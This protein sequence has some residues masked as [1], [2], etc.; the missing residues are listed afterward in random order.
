MS[1]P[2]H[3]LKVPD[4]L[5]KLKGGD[6]VSPAEVTVPPL[7]EYYWEGEHPTIRI[8]WLVSDFFPMRSVNLIV[9][10]SQAG[11]TFVALDLAVAVASG[12]PFFGKRVTKGGVLYIASEGAMTVPGRL[13]A[14]R[15]GL[16]NDEKLI[17]VIHEPPPDLMNEKDVDRIIATAQRINE[18]ML[19]ATGCPLSLII[20][21]TMVSSFAINNWNE[22]GETS[23]AMKM[24]NRIKA[25]VVG[26]AV[27]GVH[28]HGK[29]T[30][31]GAAGS[32]ALTASADAIL[33]VYKKGEDGLVN[34]R[35]ISL[36]KSR[37]GETGRKYEFELQTLPPDQREAAG[38]DQAFVNPL[39]NDL[40]GSNPK[41][42]KSSVL[43]RDEVL[44][45][46]FE[47]ALKGSGMDTNHDGHGKIRQ[48]K[49]STV[50]DRFAQSYQ[51]KGATDPVGAKQKAWSRAILAL[52][53]GPIRYGQWDGQEWLYTK[54][55]VE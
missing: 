44:K 27:I 38:D 17:A 3:E 10:E 40:S 12:R 26:A 31:R 13:K 36:T 6:T 53:E 4:F 25:G 43:Q 37:F 22:V 16:P 18:Q 34:R 20:I 23:K 51:T 35:Y 14:A 5:A 2:S 1:D 45:S 46:A 32:Y 47:A 33:S 52:G 15:Q 28:H 50:K 55:D 42:P 29:D 19:D 30:S 39:L 9:G 8:P 48:V 49:L 7:V 54:T 24:L 41:K 11:K 21:D